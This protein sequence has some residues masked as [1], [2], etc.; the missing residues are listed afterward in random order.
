[1]FNFFSM[2]DNYED[3]KIDNFSEGELSVDT[4]AITDSE[5][6]YETGISHP[7]CNSGK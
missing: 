3:R 4:C 2:A 7:Q 5:Q 1:M 6:R